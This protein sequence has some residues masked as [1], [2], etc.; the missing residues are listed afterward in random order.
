MLRA[1]SSPLA[2]WA[3]MLGGLS[4]DR[5]RWGYGAVVSFSLALAGVGVWI[6][7]LCRPPDGDRLQLR[8]AVAVCG[9]GPLW[10]TRGGIVDRKTEELR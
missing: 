8:N 2:F 9:F 4:L 3:Q 7:A 10:P 1:V 5:I 6:S